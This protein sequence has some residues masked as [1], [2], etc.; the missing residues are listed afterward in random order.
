M[1][2]KNETTP[3]LITLLTDFGTRDGYVGIMKAVMLGINPD[4]KFI[5][6]AHNIPS[7]QIAAGAYI[8]NSA[9]PYF[10]AG[11][12][13]VAVIDPGVGSGRSILI[14]EANRQYFLVPD[15][16]L[17]KFIFQTHQIRQVIRVTNSRFFLPTMSQTFHGRDIFAPV[18]AYLSLGHPLEDFG[19]WTDDFE[20]GR[21]A[22]PKISKNYVAGEI[23]H[24]DR[25]GNLITNITPEVL[26]S[27]PEGVQLWIRIGTYRING[28]A[29]CYLNGGMN[30]PIALWGSSNSLEI[31]LN[32]SRADQ[33]LNMSYG[34]EVRVEWLD[35][36]IK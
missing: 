35:N 21:L 32:Q 15:N 1:I 33:F 13:H 36:N 8:L 12:I 6:L 10:P 22:V 27:V 3:A 31:A 14:C 26:A 4:L 20:Q 2:K 11:T 25:F 16:G 18:A 5:D 9:Y 17:L 23:I 19:T 34:D 7:H 30:E 28:I 24:I 29:S